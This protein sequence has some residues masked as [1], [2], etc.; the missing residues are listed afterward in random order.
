MKKLFITCSVL[1][2][3]VACSKKPVITPSREDML[4]TGKWKV[5]SGTVHGRMPNGKDTAIDYVKFVMPDCIKDNYLVFD[6]LYKGNMF[7]GALRC[8]SGQG[9][10]IPFS[11][12]LTNNGNNIDLYN[13]LNFLYAYNDTLLTYH[14]DTLSF[15]PLILDSL[16]KAIDT[17]PGFVKALIVLDSIRDLKVTPIALPT[18][19]I[20]D[21]SITEFS[22]S[23]FTLHFSYITKYLDTTGG[24][25]STPRSLP[26]TLRYSLKFSNY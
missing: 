18:Y 14:F 1:L 4:R 19:S 2:I 11:W 3:L 24:H 5:S 23:A 6:S 12:R 22:Q 26:D 25:L 20:Y 13:G 21:A 9:D 7:N 10:R 8:D 17:T 16:V 15:D